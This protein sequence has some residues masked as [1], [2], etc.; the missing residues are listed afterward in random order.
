MPS[1]NFIHPS[2]STLYAQSTIAESRPSFS[3]QSSSS[4]PTQDAALLMIPLCFVAIWAAVV[5]VISNTWKPSRKEIERSRQTAQL[6]CKKCAYF[7][8]N[9][10]VKCAVNPQIAMTRSANDCGDFHSK[11]QKAM[12]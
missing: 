2:D 5:C 9:P 1:S 10:Y 7:S 8:N 3:S 11:D 4:V 12:R 6:P